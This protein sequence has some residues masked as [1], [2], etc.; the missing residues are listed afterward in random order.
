[1]SGQASSL[2][3]GAKG[4]TLALGITALLAALLWLGIVAPLI[5]LYQEREESLAQ[6]ST[7]LARMT[8]LARELPVLKAKANALAAQPEP[9]AQ[10]MSAPSDA[11]GAASLQNI[12][13]DLAG[14]AGASLT[15]I[16]IIPAEPA[17]EYRKLGLRLSTTVSW[18]VLIAMFNAIETSTP[19][20]L[21]D[22]LQIHG[23]ALAS[24]GEAQMLDASFVVYAFR[25][26]KPGGTKP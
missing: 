6:M 24:E 7:R 5:D 2:P 13:Q 16:E 10:T 3:T 11:V 20:I 25:S 1:M 14:K 23:S 22:D 4:R 9:V 8:R 18:S 15:S 17:G 12:V 21:L 19:P 26:A